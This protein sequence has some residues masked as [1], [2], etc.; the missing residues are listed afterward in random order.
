VTILKHEV[1][2]GYTNKKINSISQKFEEVVTLEVLL[3][4]PTSITSPV[5]IVKKNISDLKDCNYCTFLEYYYYIDNIVSLSKNNCSVHCTRDA[6]ASFHADILKQEVYAEYASKDQYDNHVEDLRMAADIQLPYD[7]TILN[8]GT[9]LSKSNPTVILRTYGSY[10]SNT[11]G[12]LTYAI[13]LDTLKNFLYGMNSYIIEETENANDWELFKSWYRKTIF[14]GNWRDNILDCFLIPYNYANF[15]DHPDWATPNIEIVLGGYVCTNYKGYLLKNAVLALDTVSEEV[16]LGSLNDYV[17]NYPWLLND[18]FFTLQLSHPNGIETI[19]S[20]D[21][22]NHPKITINLLFDVTTGNYEFNVK[23]QSSE[24]SSV[25]PII[26]LT[27]GSMRQDLLNRVKANGST[28]MGDYLSTVGKIVGSAAGATFG[29]AAALGEATINKQHTKGM[30]VAGK[31]AGSKIGQGIANVGD[32][33][34]DLSSTFTTS[35]TGI[36]GIFTQAPPKGVYP[37]C[38]A[39]SFWFGMA[40][41]NNKLENSMGFYVVFSFSVPKLIHTDNYEDF[42]KKYGY[43]SRQMVEVSGNGESY[44]QAVG[45]SVDIPKAFPHEISTIN[46]MLNNGIYIED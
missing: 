22:I 43:P 10:N 41:I 24:D 20:N 31:T 11:S 16:D 29:S 5:F 32:T 9:L 15:A 30:V 28:L 3:K 13:T 45:A 21:L 14:G 12:I 37:S 26:A 33:V 44:L 8:I 42:C 18:K 35:G 19:S 38:T 23:T 25:A 46:S 4:E 40:R 36:S 27:Q 34:A 6:L 39:N 1:T 2:F 17:K 7:N